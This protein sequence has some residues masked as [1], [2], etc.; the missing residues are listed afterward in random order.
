VNRP[1]KHSDYAV[2][3]H[4]EYAA[5]GGQHRVLVVTGKDADI[6]NGQPGFNGHLPGLPEETIWGYD[7]QITYVVRAQVSQ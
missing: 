3:D 7:F 2:G 6:K 4:I 5:F 1:A